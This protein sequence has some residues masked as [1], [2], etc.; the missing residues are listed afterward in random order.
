MTGDWVS[1]C[2][3]TAKAIEKKVLDRQLIPDLKA[4]FISAGHSVTSANTAAKPYK[5]SLMFQ[6]F[7]SQVFPKLTAEL[8]FSRPGNRLANLWEVNQ[9]LRIWYV[10]CVMLRELL[11]CQN[12]RRGHCLV[13][14][15]SL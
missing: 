9:A 2:F 7:A 6:A 10:S 4:N 12:H 3:T 14:T 5:E 15:F 11:V 13:P 8:N 1:I